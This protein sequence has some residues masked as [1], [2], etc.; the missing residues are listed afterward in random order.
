MDN[1]ILVATW[2]TGAGTIVLAAV[3]WRYVHLTRSISKSSDRNAQAAVA[4]TQV[5]VQT[6]AATER[7]MIVDAMP[8]LIAL[9]HATSAHG[10]VVS[11][12]FTVHNVGR[13]TALNGVMLYDGHEDRLPAILTGR[14][15][16]AVRA[17]RGE[18]VDGERRP[19]GPVVIEYEDAIGHRL[20]TECTILPIPDKPM[21]ETK[22]DTLTGWKPLRIV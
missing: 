7:S 20:K 9:W 17:M 4:A 2:V 16:T 19:V 3:T 14:Q 21:Y 12:N 8:L 15:E 6:L 11:I 1:P 5:A 18:M 10:D 13:S 22:Y